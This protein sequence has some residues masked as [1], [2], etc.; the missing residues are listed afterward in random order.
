M[1]HPIGR[2]PAEGNSLKRGLE[3][4]HPPVGHD[5]EFKTPG[6]TEAEGRNSFGFAVCVGE[7]GDAAHLGEPSGTFQQKFT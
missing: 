3:D 5:P 6:G 2:V 4:I 1:D 7:V